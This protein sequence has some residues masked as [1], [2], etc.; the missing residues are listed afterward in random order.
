VSRSESGQNNVE[1]VESD[2]TIFSLVNVPGQQYSAFSLS[3][4]AGE[5]TRTSYITVASFEIRTGKTP[6]AGHSPLRLTKLVLTLLE[7]DVKPTNA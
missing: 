5:D 2:I 4:G 1:A 3:G 6:F 7:R